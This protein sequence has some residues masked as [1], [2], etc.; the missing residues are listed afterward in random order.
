MTALDSAAY[1]RQQYADG[2]NLDARVQIHQRFSVNPY[3]YICWQFDHIGLPPD[4]RVLELGA[5][6]GELWLQNADRIPAG[7][8]ATLSDLS[9]GMVKTLRGNLSGKIFTYSILDAQALPFPDN[10]FDAVIA[11]FML[12]H[13]PDR[14]AALREI[15][16]VLR[17]GCSL[18]ASTIGD[19]HMREL[20]ELGNAA[21]VGVDFVDRSNPFTLENGFNQVA[22]WFNP[23]CL[24][25]YPD[26]LAVTEAEPVV[27]YLLSSGAGGKLDADAVS[28][29]RRHIGA[30]IEAKGGILHI[31]K[32]SGFFQA[33]K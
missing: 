9:S 6:T 8:R 18:F 15:W 11:N 22:K 24:Y 1:V 23:V 33:T 29:L 16:R 12:Y 2:K 4:A 27:A 26:A 32:D 10:T 5:G 3:S 7:W 17:P 20:F 30:Q 13:V 21:Q 14:D 19:N 31:T 28:K 25:R